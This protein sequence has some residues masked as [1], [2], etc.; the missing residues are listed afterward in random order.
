MAL[1]AF[2]GLVENEIGCARISMMAKEQ[3]PLRSMGRIQMRETNYLQIVK[4]GLHRTADPYKRANSHM[5]AYS[6]TSSARRRSAELIVKPICLAVR[7]FT[8]VSIRV[9]SSTGRLAGEA[10]LMILT[11]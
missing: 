9:G 11:T 5:D 2:K 1:S 4:S 10:P 6:I 3:K 8:M 7:R